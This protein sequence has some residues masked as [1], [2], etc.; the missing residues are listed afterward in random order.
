MRVSEGRD[1]TPVGGAEVVLH[2]VT[3]ES[4]GPVDT[5]TTNRLGEYVLSAP[6]LDTTATYIVSIEYAGLGYFS[7]PVQ[8]FGA[9]LDTASVLAV[10]DTTHAAPTIALAER[11]VVVRA[12]ESDGSRR[13]V[14]L[15]VLQNRGFTTR[16]AFDS[17]HPVWSGALPPNALQ[18]EVGD[19]DVSVQ[20]VQQRGDSVVVFAPIPP[21]DRQ[22][23]VSYT[24][25][26]STGELRIPIAPAVAS[27]NVLLEDSAA[28]LVGDGLA[29]RGV[30][31]LDDLFFRRYTGG[32]VMAG[33]AVAVQFSPS[34]FSLVSYWWITV[35]LAT[36]ALAA[37]LWR[38]LRLQPVQPVPTHP[39]AVAAEIVAL[40]DA[41]ARRKATA[42]DQERLEYERRRAELKQVLSQ[43]LKARS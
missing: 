23:L 9:T 22:L 41:F 4:G 18:F 42:S 25:P 15:L 35:V 14:E 5:V 24:I 38:W 30:E 16:I 36:L 13:I 1:S 12:A 33:Q 3:R 26:R 31:E 21:G 6:V 28:A 19:S 10:Y 34:S 2:Q 27:L 37:G 20:A 39:D 40:D 11:H 43:L 7:E 17:L 29:F 8:T 32:P